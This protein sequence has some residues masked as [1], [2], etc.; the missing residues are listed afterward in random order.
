MD[1]EE[2]KKIAACSAK[3]LKESKEYFSEIDAKTGDGD[4]GITIGKI[5]DK[6]IELS[7]EKTDN[8]KIRVFF[9]NLFDSIMS[10]NGGSSSMLWGMMAD[11]ITGVLTSEEI[12]TPRV[13][14]AMFEGALEGL[15]SVSDARLGDKTMMDALIPAVNVA[16]EAPDDELEILRLA[17]DAAVEGARDTADM[18]AK[19]GRAKNLHEKS[20]GYVDAGAVSLATMIK[21][22]YDCYSA[23]R[24]V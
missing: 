23:V 6:I 9:S 19:F 7:T 5:A 12:I 22:F 24:G 1:L 16:R 15:Q 3:K 10:I 4:H 18:V 14:K 11:G 2:L 17:A 20:I 13:L 8:K 21:A